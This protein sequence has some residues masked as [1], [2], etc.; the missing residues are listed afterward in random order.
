MHATGRSNEVI[1]EPGAAW[2]QCEA[3]L[4]AQGKPLP[5]FHRAIWA[6][7]SNKSGARCSFVPVRDLSGV[8]RAGFALES[9]PSRALPGHHLISIHRLGIDSGGLDDAA[10]DAGLAALLDRVRRDRSVLRVTVE[11]FAFDPESR[12]R[13]SEALRRHGFLQVRASMMYERTLVVDLTPTEEA[14][15]AG[16]HKNARQGIRNVARYPVVVT[17]AVS[18]ALAP[19]LQELSDETRQR[20]GGESRPLDWEALIRLSAEAPHLSRIAVLRRTDVTGPEGVLAF[21]WGCVHGGVAEYSESGSTRADNLKVSTSYALL[22][23]LMRWAR[24]NG[25]RWFDL[26]GVTDG[27]THSEDPLGGISDFKRRFS[28][29]EIEVGQQWDLEPHPARAAAARLVSR[30]AAMLR[31]GIRWIR[32]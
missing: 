20:T 2:Q 7:V 30:S 4:E 15:L 14:L 19:R 32:H 17:S 26:G 5:L 12:L 31:L 13:T 23:D 18:I 21:A 24:A 9:R 8:C 10:L 1:E 3:A 6:R 28:Q 11:V 27:S 16:F 25:A 22:W 29:R